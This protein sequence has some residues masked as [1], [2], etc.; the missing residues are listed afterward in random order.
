MYVYY[1]VADLTECTIITCGT[2]ATRDSNLT[3]RTFA[4]FY[5]KEQRANM[6]DVNE[7][8]VNI[9]SIRCVLL[10]LT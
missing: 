6:L 3:D 9:Y 4:R 2:A 1:D 5:T 8:N 7:P 10:L